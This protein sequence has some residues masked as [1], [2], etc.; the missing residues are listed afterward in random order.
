M[1]SEDTEGSDYDKI[2]LVFRLVMLVGLIIIWW[3]EIS[4]IYPI[5]PSRRS[6]PGGVLLESLKH[7]QYKPE[8]RRTF[9]QVSAFHE[10]DS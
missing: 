9:F 1:G 6:G 4:R 7:W 5:F 2:K 8:A 10:S 3:T